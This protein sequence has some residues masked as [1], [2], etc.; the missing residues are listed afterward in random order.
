M[1]KKIE[2]S[3]EVNPQTLLFR[4]KETKIDQTTLSASIVVI[5]IAVAAAFSLTI[6]CI[7]ISLFRYFVI[8]DLCLLSV[9]NSYFNIISSYYCDY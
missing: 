9:L 4:S 1:P 8:S 3:E 5:V 7:F 2:G 6:Y